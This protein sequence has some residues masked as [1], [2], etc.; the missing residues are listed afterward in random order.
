M[1]REEE[2]QRYDRQ[3]R[4]Q[5]FG[6]EGQKKLKEAS[7]LV[8]GIGGLGTVIS[9]YLGVAGVGRLR[10]VDGEVV[11]LSN[12]NR[13]ILHWTEDI[14]K[15]KARSAEEKLQKVNPHIQIEATTEI[16]TQDNVLKLTEGCHLILDAMDNYQARYLLNRA[17]L[18]RG[19]PF[20]HGGIYGMEGVMTTIIP[21]QT[22]CLR[23]IF[24]EPPP[25]ATLPV[26]GAAPGIIGCLQAL[27]AIK[28]IT[29]IGRLL[30]DRLLIFDGIDLSFR[31][32]KLERNP[33]CPDC[34]PL[35]PQKVKVYRESNPEQ[36]LA[37]RRND[38]DDQK[39]C[40]GE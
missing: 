40:A 36:G 1:L 4:I 28:H 3:I 2:K 19:I 27:E 38:Q 35:K 12:L 31:E 32:V 17:A 37:I 26:L 24:P 30:T 22:A 5:G 7:V 9:M 25:Q 16:I 39:G 6:E 14:G 23:C 15:E 33:Q 10:I 21:G 11:E 34:S 13:Q 8:A 29:G 18:E 20:I